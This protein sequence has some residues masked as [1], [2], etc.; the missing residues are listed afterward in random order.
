MSGNVITQ[1]TELRARAQQFDPHPALGS[2]AVAFPNA[3]SDH[4]DG[5]GAFLS[6]SFIPMSG[7]VPS[8]GSTTGPSS[9]VGTASGERVQSTVFTFANA[10]SA[11]A[12][13]SVSAAQ[14]FSSPF[15]AAHPP[16]SSHSHSRKKLDTSP[17]HNYQPPVYASP[18]I[19]ARG[20]GISNYSSPLSPL[21]SSSAYLTVKSPYGS[22]TYASPTKMTAIPVGSPQVRARVC[23]AWSTLNVEAKHAHH[24]QLMVCGVCV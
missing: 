13:S 6:P 16:S 11:K 18:K 24:G 22:P 1:L 19:H 15:P 2:P 21:P 14:M 8:G 7:A 9:R 12:T 20:S 17:P 10:G 3:T 4:Q 5:G 23:I